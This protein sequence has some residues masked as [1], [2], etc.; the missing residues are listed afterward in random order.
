M[1]HASRHSYCP[2]DATTL[3]TSEDSSRCPKCGYVDYQ[4][5]APCVGFFIHESGRVL[6]SR[7]GVEPAV[8][9]WDIP[10]GFVDAGESTEGAVRRE[11]AEETTLVVEPV[12]CLG[13]LPDIY[14]SAGREYPTL[15]FIYVARRVSGEPEPTDDV[16]ELRWFDIDAIPALAFPHQVQAVRLLRRHL[17]LP[18][19]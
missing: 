15:N 10:G 1:S 2:F 3:T 12:V 18:D 14:R 9:E 5:P 8:G 19:E 6:L 7:R 4:N 13:S 11:A 16:T 17:G